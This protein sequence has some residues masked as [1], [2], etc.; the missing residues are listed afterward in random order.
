[1]IFDWLNKEKSKIADN[2]ENLIADDMFLNYSKA[3]ENLN[4]KEYKLAV[5]NFDKVIDTLP[6]A[7]NVPAE[8]MSMT[9]FASSDMSVSFSL[10]DLYHN[11]GCAKFYTSDDSSID[12]FTEAIKIHKDYENAYYMRG[13]AYFILLEDW[14]KAI[15]DIKKYLTFSPDD[16]AGNKLLLVLEEIKENSEEINKLYTKALHDFS[17]GQKMLSFV[18]DSK[19]GISDKVVDEKKGNQL[20]KLC[21]KSL[22]KAYELFSQKNRP[23]IY[24]KSHSFS[25]VE[26]LFKKLQCSL[27][28]QESESILS[29]CVGIYKI[30]KGLFK[31]NKSELGAKIYYMIVEKTNSELKDKIKSKKN[32]VV[33]SKLRVNWDE[34]NDVGIVTY[35]KN[36]PFVGIGFSLHEN[37]SVREEQEMVDGLKHG[38]GKLFLKNGE[39]ACKINYVDDEFETEKDKKKYQ[40]SLIKLILEDRSS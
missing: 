40:K 9:E 30:S 38:L 8:I 15:L 29:Q 21:V 24:L 18:D 6:N 31:P 13:S 5:Q 35:Y 14:Q 19:Q 33:L 7:T 10:I 16:N 1:M 3:Q 20:M 26:I 27:M 17:E 36:K 25:L 2:K 23:N 39:V 34:M 32:K 11:R 37:G 28:L 12:D 4:N 22:D